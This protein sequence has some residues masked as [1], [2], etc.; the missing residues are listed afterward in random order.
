MW[1]L[2]PASIRYSQDG[3]TASFAN[4]TRIDNAARALVRDP[5]GADKYDPIRIT[6][7]KGKYISLDNRRLW[8]FRHA[9]IPACRVRWASDVEVRQSTHFDS[10]EGTAFVG[11]RLGKSLDPKGLVP[12]SIPKGFVK[13]HADYTYM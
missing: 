2:S 3:I 8:V 12:A 10:P 4:G 6:S 1:L 13:K 11:V 9:G 7:R 5:S